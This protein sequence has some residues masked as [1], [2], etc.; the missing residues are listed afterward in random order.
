[1]V[2]VAKK[3]LALMLSGVLVVGCSS[4]A[5]NGGS[6]E[7][8]GAAEGASA[9]SVGS[10]WKDWFIEGTL[11]SD[12]QIEA[13]DDFY[14]A[15]NRDWLLEQQKAGN[16]DGGTVANRE[17]QIKD[18][19]LQVL[20]GNAAG[21][22]QTS[23]DVEVLKSLYNLFEDWDGRDKDGV[24]PL[25]DIV[26]HLQLV[27]T[28]E[29]FTAWL[30]SDEYKL[31]RSWAVDEEGRTWGTSLFGISPYRLIGTR[32]TSSESSTNDAS[33]SSTESMASGAATTESTATGSGASTSAT[34]ATGATTNGSATTTTGTTTT[35]GSTSAG[36]TTTT[37]AT[38]TTGTATTTGATT[39]TGTTATGSDAAGTVTGSS[40]TMNRHGIRSMVSFMEGM[41]YGLDTTTGGQGTGTS[42]DGYVVEILPPNFDLAPF[43]MSD[44]ELE[45][46]ENLQKFQ[47]ASGKVELAERMLVRLGYS[48][49]E[50]DKVIEK[51]IDLE[52]DLSY[53]ITNSSSN[54]ASYTHEEFAERCKDGFPI[55]AIVDAYGY[56]DADAYEIY[57]TAWYDGLSNYY[58]KSRVD[59]FVAHALVALVVDNANLL[60]TEAYNDM[61]VCDGSSFLPK[62]YASQIDKDLSS[63]S[64]A[65]A[66]TSAAGTTG[67]VAVN[68]DGSLT[69]VSPDSEPIYDTG[70]ATD[71]GAT[72]TTGTTTGSTTGTTTG[73]T[74]PTATGSGVD[75][76]TLKD[77]ARILGNSFGG[78]TKT[79]SRLHSLRMARFRA[80]DA[81]AMNSTT[82]VSSDDEYGTASNASDLS[83]AASGV[84]ATGVDGADEFT[85]TGTST[86]DATTTGTTTTG[87]TTTGTTATTE[88]GSTSNSTTS[89]TTT[90]S[91]PANS[92]GTSSVD[93]LSDDEYAEQL[94]QYELEERYAAVDAVGAVLPTSYAKV[95]VENYYDEGTTERVKSMVQQIVNEYEEMLNGETWM[96]TDARKEA[97]EKLKAIHIQVGHPD[98]WA[99]TSNTQ[100]ASRENGGTLFSEVRRINEQEIEQEL[101]LLRSS[102]NGSYW[103]DC[104]SVNAWYDAATN[105]ITIGAGILGGDYWPE[106]ASEERLLGATGVTIGHE[107]S[108]A[109][110][111]TGAYFNKDGAYNNWWSDADVASFERRVKKAEDY[112][113]TIKPLGEEG[114]N[115]EQVAA[116]CIADMAGLKAVMRLAASKDG[117]NYD[118]FFK[119]YAQTWASYMSMDMALQQMQTDA[120][121]LDRDRVNIP[122]REVDEFNT[123]YDIHEGDGM[124]LAPEN[125]ISVW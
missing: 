12:T 59:K 75:D 69:T 2:N 95:Y 38:T 13:K 94:K 31:S 85:M 18:Q 35:S 40:T 100:V 113:S 5:V 125:R 43:W 105:S 109:F 99:D 108:H 8:A 30:E 26:E 53:F 62:E 57:D 80:N 70:N 90:S 119:A 44:S 54:Y 98:E 20:E 96:S 91:T 47:E 78:G 115:G 88:T 81:A 112:L 19:M 29:E 45:N 10:P 106:G 121:P 36:S 114:Y 58:D 56:K 51:A 89:T 24:E 37:G 118:E 65:V 87:T 52:H 50:A 60:D 66:G 103:N 1:M 111:S 6:S 34:T 28:I 46:T 41:D 93:S 4:P 32:D 48:L 74:T 21:S 64:E 84:A 107:I 82:G 120:H 97:V 73:T 86:T 9:G 102:A 122:V 101:A 63:A 71:T 79:R 104:I 67:V 124:W 7:G 49:E 3:A 17:L 14:T 123:T 110:D 22:A 116:E 11:T 92:T 68:E 77:T 42:Y 72:T 76:E 23:H 61:V 33:S 39:T 25:K 117:F 27:K 55:D 16:V 15:V 83:T